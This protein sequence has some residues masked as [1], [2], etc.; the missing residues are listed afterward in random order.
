V[1]L[2]EDSSDPDGALSP[3]PHDS[4]P[5]TPGQA[6]ALADAAPSDGSAPVTSN[7]GQNRPMAL[8]AK[9]FGSGLLRSPTTGG[10]QSATNAH[11]L[12][13]PAVAVRNLVAQSRQGHLCTVMS[14]MAGRPQRVPLRGHGGLRH[15]LERPPHL[16]PLPL[17][18]HARNLLADPGVPSW[19]RFR[20]GAAWRTQG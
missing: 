12:P 14:R 16:L 3:P 1:V 17:E 10:V 8:Q 11:G 18:I 5:A 13:D 15:R 4:A 19:Y 20:G 7:Q 6:P 9:A 2:D